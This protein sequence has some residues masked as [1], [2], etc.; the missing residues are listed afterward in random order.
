VRRFGDE[1]HPTIPPAQDFGEHAFRFAILTGN[2]IV[3]DIV[4]EGDPA[5]VERQF[6]SVI[7]DVL[8]VIIVA[9]LVAFEIMVAI[10][11]NSLSRPLDQLHALLRRQSRGDFSI[12]LG[13]EIR[14]SIDRVTAR[15]SDHSRD[16][17]ARFGRLLAHCSACGRQFSAL[18]ELRAL[19]A[20]CGLSGETSVSPRISDIVDMRLPLFLFVLAEELSK[21]FLPLYVRAA[22]PG[23]TWMSEEVIISL[24]L[25]AYL[26]ALI[27]LS[28]V[29][30]RIM[31]WLGTRRAFLLAAAPVLVSHLG[32]G[33]SDSVAEIML[34]RGVA[35]A[36]YA[37]ATIA[38]QDYALA[39]GSGGQ[40]PRAIG[41]FIAVIISGTFCGTA[42]GGVLADRIGQSNVFFVGA[43]LVCVAGLMAFIMITG[44]HETHSPLATRAGRPRSVFSAFRSIE[45]VVLLF[46][47]AIPANVLLAAFLWYLVPLLLAD[48]GAMPAD[49]GRAVMLYYWMLLIVTPR[50]AQLLDRMPVAS[51]LVTFGSLL[52][53]LALLVVGQW[54]GFWPILAA[55]VMAGV[56]QSLLRAPMVEI[57]LRIGESRPEEID[58]STVLAALRTF[59]RVGS[60]AG[61]FL[62]AFVAN[63][64]GYGA[65]TSVTGYMVIAGA[66]V[67]AVSKRFAVDAKEKSR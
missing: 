21:S 19:G 41:S 18:N 1:Q 44:K 17:N 3:G 39:A 25:I 63:K 15:F 62:T 36:G 31:K 24:P 61:L 22:A 51:T 12:R 45:F 33:L 30:E 37:I 27:V 10:V 53:G 8:V 6:R 46:G 67:F 48:S 49:I 47:I 42:I 54:Q 56:G 28:S 26:F 5:F 66:I 40:R 29:S 64:M 7:L 34:W 60:M 43:G 14:T 23:E 38:C 4:I 58:A 16:L 11:T 55:I 9:V 13:Q 2:T 65:A 59:E 52:S 20:R 35:G 57:A 32:L 50:S